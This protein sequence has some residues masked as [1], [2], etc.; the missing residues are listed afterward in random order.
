MQGR[1]NI[2]I[3]QWNCRSISRNLDYLI[4]YLSNKKHQILV[5]QSLYVNKHKLPKLP[6]YYYPPVFQPEDEK[7]KVNTAIHI[8]E[9]LNYIDILPPIPKD[10][11]NIDACAA[12]IRFHD[13][14]ILN[15]ISVY[16]P[17]G[18]DNQ[19][20][21]WLRALQDQK[22][23]WLIAGDFNTHSPF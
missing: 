21:K 16:L 10:I 22:E 17:K 6:N 1:S 12:R 4:Q 23:K 19:N 5:L 2:D 11:Q 13:S 3:L 18:P 20:T 8:Q 14:L 15:I 9:N 7:G